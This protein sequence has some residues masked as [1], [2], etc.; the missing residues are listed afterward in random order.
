LPK[1]YSKEKLKQKNIAIIG[2]GLAGLA[3]AVEL[4]K[5]GINFTL[6]EASDSAG[7]QIRTIKHKGVNL[8]RGFQV[9]MES[10]V[11]TKKLAKTVDP[12]NQLSKCFFEAGALVFKD[13][14]FR[15]FEDPLR[16]PLRL[17]EVLATDL[18]SF[19]DKIK[20]V[21]LRLNLW[22]K[23]YF[24][25]LH[26]SQAKPISALEFLQQY[27]FSDQFINNFAKPFFG[28]VFGESS[29]CTS[30]NNFQ[31]CFK[32]FSEGRVYLP[33]GGIQEFVDLIVTFLPKNCLRTKTKVSALTCLNEQI[34]L[35][36]QNNTQ[37][38]F[39]A[40]VL[41]VDPEAACEL[42]KIEAQSISR[43]R[44]FNLYFLS[45]V[46]LYSEKKLFL[47]AYPDKK[48]QASAKLI[49]NGMQITNVLSNTLSGQG[50]REQEYLISIT[51]LKNPFE[52]NE[53]MIKE[54]ISELEAMFPHAQG[55]VSYLHHFELKG[56]SSQLNQSPE[57]LATIKN[58]Y[59]KMEA[60]CKDSNLFLAGDAYGG[61]C[62]QDSAIKSGVR[63]VA[64]LK[65]LL[66]K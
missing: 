30:N 1:S 9:M 2:G 19:I 50:S 65:N 25:I 37:E 48:Q 56:N 15:R 20:L 64:K 28:G 45:K 27:G 6:F 7:G 12:D 31:Y 52:D 3:A 44:Y 24:K 5:E 62:S 10:S 54:V 51:V 32:A 33:S 22:F 13:G 11:Y 23:S 4:H 42:L 66:S 26:G 16:N 47:S 53:T 61:I 21:Q 46:S 39:D 55:A 17:F 58:I 36:L 63:A 40:V 57:S 43:Q 41:T 35:D 29:L 59:S 49:N 18:V 38:I 60:F 34:L 8:D 14:K